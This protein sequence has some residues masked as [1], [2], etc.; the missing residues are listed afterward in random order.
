MKS[1]SASLVRASISFPSDIYQNLQMLAKQNK[2]SLA[3]VVREAVEMYVAD[4]T[5]DAGKQAK[6]AVRATK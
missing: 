6:R 3:W 1:P 4:A 2:V 5:A